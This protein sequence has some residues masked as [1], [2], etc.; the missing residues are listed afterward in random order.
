MELRG[1]EKGV[2]VASVESGSKAARAGL[3]K[4]DIIRKVKNK[5]VENLS[6]FEKAIDENQSPYALSIER[7]GTNLFVAVR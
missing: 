3:R 2:F 7:N 1:G 6:E 4:G 5:S